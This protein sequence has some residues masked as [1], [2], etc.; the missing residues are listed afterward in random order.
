M[1]VTSL[2]SVNLEIN[3]KNIAVKDGSTFSAVVNTTNKKGQYVIFP[4]NMA[5]KITVESETPLEDGKEYNVA[6]KIIDDKVTLILSPQRNQNEKVNISS[7]NLFSDSDLL[8]KIDDVTQKIIKL[9]EDPSVNSKQIDKLLIQLNRLLSNIDGNHKLLEGL[10][11]IVENIFMYGVGEKENE[12]LSK[13]KNILP[14]I[15][16]FVQ[17]GA[18]PIV[19]KVINK[20]GKTLL[21]Y[22]FNDK[23]I[24][25][26]KSQKSFAGWCLEKKDNNMLLDISGKT[27][28]V[29]TKLLLQK[30]DWIFGI[31]GKKDNKSINFSAK[32]E[33][34]FNIAVQEPLNKWGVSNSKINRDI[35]KFLMFKKG[36]CSKADLKRLIS[37]TKFASNKI[38]EFNIKNGKVLEKIWTISNVVQK[39]NTVSNKSLEFVLRSVV[40]SGG[41]LSDKF[42][43][44]FKILEMMDK[45]SDISNKKISSNTI[46][47]IK[48]LV[49]NINNDIG[50]KDIL[51]EKIENS[52]MFYESNLVKWFTKTNKSFKWQGDT[53]AVLLN[54]LRLIGSKS[55]GDSLQQNLKNEVFKALGN[56]EEKQL[57]PDLKGEN[58]FIPSAIEEEFVPLEIL[59]ENNKNSMLAKKKGQQIT[60]N[61][62][63]SKIGEIKV[64]ITM[65]KKELSLEIYCSNKKAL[66]VFEN[67]F[68]A[69][70]KILQKLEI[71]VKKISAYPYILT[72]GNNSLD[73]TKEIDIII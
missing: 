32:I 69:L 61:C 11:S 30:G 1:I 38:P 63:T 19:E 18:K 57:L 26:T 72:E 21:V 47:V 64:G 42:D 34:E 35:M 39:N 24:I 51:P 9:L 25:K 5:G 43:N 70:R 66:P 48:N 46:N 2:Q 45:S 65:Y 68:M 13:L 37:I 22:F 28:D 3:G 10:K 6:V 29:K 14:E 40:S 54:V 53:K 59:F 44:L 60:I 16:N 55:D 15:L 41:K 8:K 73:N 17:Q 50:T 27:V 52:G 49:L 56:I 4:K 36:Y 7:L 62:K 12:S 33:E 20:E 67:E 71:N 23:S 31:V 58:I